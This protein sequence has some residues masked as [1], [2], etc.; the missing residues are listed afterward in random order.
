MITKICPYCNNTFTTEYDYKIYCNYRCER[1]ALRLRWETKRYKL[2]KIN[3]NRD[4]GITL[5]KL[6]IRDNYTC[7]ICKKPIDMSDYTLK[8]NY[9]I[10]GK[11]YPTI[12][13]I[14]PLSKGGTHTWNN[15]AIAHMYCNCVVKEYNKK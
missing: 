6:L 4:K 9:F 14:I 2:I 15:V 1:R 11:K 5:K 8:D 10:F 12:D 13:H 7:Y 3:G